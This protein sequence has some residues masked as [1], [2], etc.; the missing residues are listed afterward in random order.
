MKRLDT[1]APGLPRGDGFDR[2]FPRKRSVAARGAG[3]ALGAAAGAALL[4]AVPGDAY[5]FRPR[6]PDQLITAAD[7][8]MRWDPGIGTVTFT[9]PDT[10]ALPDAVDPAM[11]ARVVRNAVARW[12]RVPGSALR[13]A[14]VGGAAANTADLGINGSNDVYFWPQFE[15]QVRGTASI[16]ELAGWDPS[17]D[18]IQEC[19]VRINPAFPDYWFAE[20]IVEQELT[21]VV[22]HEIGH[23]FGLMHTEPYPVPIFLVREDRAPPVFRPSPTMAYT[24]E[25][26]ELS[27]DDRVAMALL[28]PAL[29]FGASRGAVAGRVTLNGAPARFAYVQTFE[30]RAGVH[31][32]PGAFADENG[33]FHVAGVRPGRVLLWVHPIQ[34]D[35]GS[36][37]P[38]LIAEAAAAGVLD[39]QDQWRWA[40]VTAGETLVIPDITLAR[41]RVPR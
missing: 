22:T 36:A 14:V 40:E 20:G 38:H 23:C 28:Y 17:G 3:W 34:V 2:P 21:N 1:G 31:P 16:A 32:G 4:L 37:S 10:G 29:G 39:F 24:S 33:V 6:S 5:R 35:T 11:W 19:D 15:G 18:R 41:G 12:D 26:G 27:E 7:S 25:Q 9:V 8:A 30:A 13:V